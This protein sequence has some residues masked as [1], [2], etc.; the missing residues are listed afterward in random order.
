M[1]AIS[2][3]AVITARCRACGCVGPAWQSLSNYPKHKLQRGGARVH[4]LP[5]LTSAVHSARPP[6]RAATRHVPRYAQQAC[7]ATFKL[8]NLQASTTADHRH[9]PTLRRT[10]PGCGYGM[11]GAADRGVDGEWNFFKMGSSSRSRP[12]RPSDEPDR[13]FHRSGCGAHDASFIGGP[14]CDDHEGQRRRRCGVY[15]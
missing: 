11:G 1:S 3:N 13:G 4:P 15:G 10:Y 14:G 7:A 2:Q 9:V 5:V 8:R 6:T 12:P